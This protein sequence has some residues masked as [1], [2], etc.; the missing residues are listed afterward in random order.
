MARA[1]SR[2]ALIASV[3]ADDTTLSGRLAGLSARAARPGA[4]DKRWAWT[5]I[6]ENRERSNYEL[7]A[8]ATGFWSSGSLDDLR[9]YAARYVSDIPRLSEWVGR[10]PRPGRPSAFP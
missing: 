8:L 10:T 1:G 4:D 6:T 5:E 7:N 9:P 3:E 2:C